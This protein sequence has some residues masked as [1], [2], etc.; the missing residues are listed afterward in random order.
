[1]KKA[2]IETIGLLVII[3][4]LVLLATLFVS[5]YLKK[6]PSS[7]AEARTSIKLSNFLNSIAKININN[8]R[9]ADLVYNCYTNQDCNPLQQHLTLITNEFFKN[10]QFSY[11]FK[12]N[13][14]EFYTINTCNLGLTADYK[15]IKNNIDF[16]IILKTC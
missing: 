1:M 10:Q 5:F 4:L 15:F 8:Q 9:L 12:A 16:I 6:A 3:I 2:Q 7:I 11:T 13:N 14:Q